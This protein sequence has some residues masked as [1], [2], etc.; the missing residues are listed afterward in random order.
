MKGLQLEI[1]LLDQLNHYFVSFSS[2][3][4]S[5][6]LPPYLLLLFSPIL[7]AVIPCSLNNIDIIKKSFASSPPSSEHFPFP[8]RQLF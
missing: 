2:P 4:W 7:C 8:V 6:L 1:S 3:N 5:V